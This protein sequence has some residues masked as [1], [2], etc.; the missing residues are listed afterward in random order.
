MWVGRE[1]TRTHTAMG[2]KPMTTNTNTTTKRERGYA[3]EFRNVN[4]ETV[5]AK[6]RFTSRPV[7]RE[8]A[9]SIANTNVIVLDMVGTWGRTERFHPEPPGPYIAPSVSYCVV[10]RVNGASRCMYLTGIA[11]G[12]HGSWWCA[13]NTDIAL[14]WTVADAV[15][16]MDCDTSPNRPEYRV[17]PLD[18]DHNAL[19]YAE[20]NPTPTDGVC[21]YCGASHVWS[22]RHGD[23]CP[24]R[25]MG[26]LSTDAGTDEPEPISSDDC[27]GFSWFPC[28]RCN[29]GLGGDRY[30]LVIIDGGEPVDMTVCVD[31]YM[32]E[33][34]C[35]DVPMPIS[36]DAP[37]SE[38]DITRYMT[39]ETDP[40]HGFLNG[41]AAQPYVGPK[42]I[43]RTY[44]NGER[45]PVSVC[46][47]A[48]F[49]DPA[50]V[51]AK[52]D[53]WCRKHGYAAIVNPYLP[54]YR[55]VN[56]PVHSHYAVVD[57]G[58]GARQWVWGCNEPRT[59]SRDI[60]QC[61]YRI[62]R[63]GRGQWLLMGERSETHRHGSRSNPPMWVHMD[64][65]TV[66]Q[67]EHAQSGGFPSE[68]RDGD[69]WYLVTP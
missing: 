58:R 40:E 61:A 43:K 5:I 19:W 31:C 50:S 17:Y 22:E 7:A 21:A 25:P 42:P 2:T 55:T 59:V 37:M 41:A 28:D 33:Y 47:I 10:S 4:G 3:A 16:L 46:D 13:G 27:L 32:A 20:F 18:G 64:D 68:T 1:P 29:S 66:H 60:Q 67:S 49:H 69:T 51:R 48:H 57:T 14:F 62:H 56:R 65:M 35:A 30:R 36:G 15:A 63:N 26:W 24:N 52:F 23:N 34:G 53:G 54:P 38:P 11:D 45:R 12:G 39:V 6:T 9:Q 8:Y 44:R